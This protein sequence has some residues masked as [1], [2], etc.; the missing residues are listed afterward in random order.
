MDSRFTNNIQNVFYYVL[1]ITRCNDKSVPLI[2][3]CAGYSK[4]RVNINNVRGVLLARTFFQ[5][6]KESDLIVGQEAQEQFVSNRARHG[7]SRFKFKTIDQSHGSIVNRDTKVTKHYRRK[8][9]GIVSRPERGFVRT[10]TR[11]TSNR[12]IVIAI[13]NTRDSHFDHRV[14]CF[15]SKHGYNIACGRKHFFARETPDE[16]PCRAPKGPSKAILR[17]GR[18]RVAPVAY[19]ILFNF[20]RTNAY[21]SEAPWTYCRT[22]SV[23]FGLGIVLIIDIMYGNEWKERVGVT[24]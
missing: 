22:E 2:D 18:E 4:R 14:V 16:S 11:I 17:I 10:T 24:A 9:T 5:S 12:R 8:G 21:C 15:L 3:H 7:S 1:C 20:I 19:A 23:L 6:H 13:R